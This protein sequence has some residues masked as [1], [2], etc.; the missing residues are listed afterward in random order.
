MER[1]S[2]PDSQSRLKE[3]GHRAHSP[4][5]FTNRSA[6]EPAPRSGAAEIEGKH[7]GDAARAE[8]RHQQAIDAEGHAGAVRQAMS[9]RREQVFVQW[10]RGMSTA[11]ANIDI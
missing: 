8:Y 11:G 4:I 9:E 2:R 3:S 7:V 5:P 6:N 1:L 10:R